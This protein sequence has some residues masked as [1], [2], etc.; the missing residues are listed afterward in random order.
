MRESATPSHYFSEFEKADLVVLQSSNLCN[1]DCF[2]CKLPERKT[3]LRMNPNSIGLIFTNLLIDNLL[4]PKVTIC[5]HLG[6]PLT[7]DL[8]WYRQA[9]AALEEVLP[10]EF[11]P[12][13]MFQTNGTLLT[14]KWC[15]FFAEKGIEIGLSLD[16]P[17]VVHDAHRPDW[18]GHS[19][20]EKTIRGLNLL[21]RHNIPYYIIAVLDKSILKSG[22]NFYA[23]FKDLGV[24]R[25]CLN[26]EESEGLEI[27]RFLRDP[28]APK[29]LERFFLELYEVVSNDPDPMWIRE[30]DHMQRA[31]LVGDLQHTRSQETILGK[32]LT[33]LQNGDVLGFT[34]GFATLPE[35]ERR[36]FVLGNVLRGPLS[37]HVQREA[38][39]ELKTQVSDTVA[40]CRQ[41]CEFHSICG[42]GSPAHRWSEHR[43]LAIHETATCRASVQALARGVLLGLHARIAS[44]ASAI[45]A[46]SGN[47]GCNTNAGQDISSGR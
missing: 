23:Y 8:S 44:N 45:S 15:E 14:A 39:A 38:L 5:W 24:R 7:L 13:L 32:V 34:P 21:Q 33:I 22:K 35:T 12:R 10:S 43:N 47:L 46:S 20:H 27:S 28:D 30:I 36:Q 11:A 42:G 41:L 2:Y 25:L 16:G 17:A 29:F 31:I 3:H 4:Q 19:S 40:R 1:L 6:E 37:Q 9:H 26:V 18:A